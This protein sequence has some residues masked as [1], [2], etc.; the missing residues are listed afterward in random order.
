VGETYWF[1]ASPT[2]WQESQV[3]LDAEETHHAVHVLRLGPTDTPIFVSDGKGTVARCSVGNVDGGRLVAKIEE[4]HRHPRPQPEIVIYQA[5][6][7]GSKIDDTI[8]A[9]GQLGVASLWVFESSRSVVRWTADK[10]EKLAARWE[11]L[12]RGAAKQSRN[13]FVLETGPPR[14][15]GELIDSISREPFAVTLWENA[16]TPL[17]QALPVAA[18]RIALVV[19]PEGGF[20]P[21]EAAALATAGAAPVSLGS[22]IF[23]TEMAPVVACSALLWHYGLIG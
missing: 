5:A 3:L 20:S 22:R 14:S 15:W 4:S 18:G 19:G 12:A 6:S 17:R 8:D 23:R 16:P 11:A 13:P 10:R 1:I 7:K 9:S 2:A 21:E